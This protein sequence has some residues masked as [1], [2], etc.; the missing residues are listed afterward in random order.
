MMFAALP[1]PIR[2]TMAAGVACLAWFGA[3]QYRGH[4]AFAGVHRYVLDAPHAAL[5]ANFDAYRIFPLPAQFRAQL[6]VT[7]TGLLAH[8]Q[9]RAEVTPEAADLAWRIG[10]TA[11]PDNPTLLVARAEYLVNAGRWS[12]ID[13]LPIRHASLLPEAR[14]VAAAYA[15]LSQDAEGLAAIMTGRR[16]TGFEP[17]FAQFQIFQETIPCVP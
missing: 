10:L 5:S 14:L 1:L 16:C 3:V 4:I 11:G 7:L 17:Q 15:A 13:F 12:E 9:D 8:Y 6:P 2:L